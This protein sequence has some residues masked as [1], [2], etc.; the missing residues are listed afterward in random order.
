MNVLWIRNW[1][2]RALG[3][4]QHDMM[5]KIRLLSIIALHIYWKNI[6]AIFHPIII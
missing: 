3:G 5:S 2:S 1:T 6:P 4:E